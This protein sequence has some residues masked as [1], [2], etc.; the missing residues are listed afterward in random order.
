MH[1]PLEH[2][3]PDQR[4]LRLVMECQLPD[5]R[6]LRVLRRR[7]FLLREHL[8]WERLL[9]ERPLPGHLGHQHQARRLQHDRARR[10]RDRLPL[11]ASQKETDYQRQAAYTF[12]F[13]GRIS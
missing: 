8:L 11:A 4:L 5:E 1:Q 3:E 2:F 6:P 9:R 7:G 10:P 13:V 12:I